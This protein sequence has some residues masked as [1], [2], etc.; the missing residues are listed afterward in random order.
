LVERLRSAGLPS[1]WIPKRENFYR[2]ASIATLGTGKTDLRA[3]RE[4]ANE[5]VGAG[6]AKAAE[7]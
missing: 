2:V 7:V 4:L 5:L 1:L 3:V 6:S